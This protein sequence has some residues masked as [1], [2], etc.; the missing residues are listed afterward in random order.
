MT[1]KETA[2][3]FFEGVFNCASSVF[4]AFCED[5]DLDTELALKLTGGMGGGFG[6]GEICGALAGAVLVVGLKYGQYIPGDKGTK[7]NCNAKR[8]QVIEAFRG[9]YGAIDCNDLL[10]DYPLDPENE[11][12]M[13]E[14]RRFCTSLVCGAVEIL[15]ELGY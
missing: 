6:E 1:K 4:G 10:A 11:T 5:Y 15:E 8:A 13:Q 9:K 3:D 2:T 14:R 12:A 7:A